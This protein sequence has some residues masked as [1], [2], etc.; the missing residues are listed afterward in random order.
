MN[1]IPRYL[2]GGTTDEREQARRASVS[3]LGGLPVG[4]ERRAMEKI[5]DKVLAT[6]QA[7]V[8]RRKQE[9]EQA[10]RRRDEAHN[11]ELIDVLRRSGAE[12]SVRVYLSRVSDSLGMLE[13]RHLLRFDSLSEKSQITEALRKQIRPILVQELMAQP[14]MPADAVSQRID[15]LVRQLVGKLGE[16]TAE[17]KLPR[18]SVRR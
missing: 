16:Q 15:R 18:S 1:D 12:S 4:T 10:S 8:V 11:K 9:E 17:N 13:R 5:R 2:T 14:S 6:F 3:A 7:T